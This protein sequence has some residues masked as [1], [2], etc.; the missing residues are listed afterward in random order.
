M[1]SGRFEQCL[2]SPVLIAQA[3]LVV[4][5]TPRLPEA[6][7]PRAGSSGRGPVLRLLILGDSSA[8]GVGVDDQSFALSGQLARALSDHCRVDWQLVGRTGMTTR[9]M[10]GLLAQLQPDRFD[11]AVTALGVNDAT[12]L[13][14]PER[15][16]KDTLKLHDLLQHQLGIGWVYATAMPPIG[17][18][19][20]LPWPLAQ[21]LGRQADAMSQALERAVTGRRTTRIVYPDWG[22]DPATMARD[23]FHPGADI[24]ARWARCLADRIQDDL[25][26]AAQDIPRKGA[27][28]RKSGNG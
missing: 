28:G 11:I 1:L 23:G 9:A 16:V 7:G 3:L 8:A 27:S 20:A 12:R 15:W 19:P 6:T 5:R 14:A 24:Y 10:P 13:V 26:P 2:L 21:V 17:D 18:F 4:G 22:F 25:S